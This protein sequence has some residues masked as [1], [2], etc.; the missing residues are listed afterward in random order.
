[1]FPEAR[2]RVFRIEGIDQ[3]RVPPLQRTCSAGGIKERRPGHLRRTPMVSRG[4]QKGL[5]RYAHKIKFIVQSTLCQGRRPPPLGIVA[6]EDTIV[7]QTVLRALIRLTKRT[8]WSSPPIG[9]D[10]GRKQDALNAL[11]AGIR[12]VVALRTSGLERWRAGSRL[13]GSTS[14]ATPKTCPIFRFQT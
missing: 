9:C 1:M 4:S 14:P 13:A 2:V 7:Q 11:R 6:L 12:K 3:Q 8:F 10:P 5:S